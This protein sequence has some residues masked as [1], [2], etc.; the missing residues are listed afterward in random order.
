MVAGAVIETVV[1]YQV[2]S[3]HNFALVALLELAAIC[4]NLYAY[5]TPG[6]GRSLRGAVEWMVP[7]AEGRLPWT[8]GAQ[9][10][11]F[12]KSVW[13][14]VYRAAAIGY[15]DSV[16]RFAAIAAAQPGANS[17]RERLLRPYPL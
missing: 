9:V 17:S 12:D 1:H 14:R 5:E 4:P 3:Y 2:E 11:P 16:R 7:Y 15:P 10:R 8:A 6:D 13:A